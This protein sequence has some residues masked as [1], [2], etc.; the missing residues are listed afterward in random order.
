MQLPL[1]PLLAG[2]RPGPPA[3]VGQANETNN[4]RHLSKLFV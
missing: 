3:G 1:P 2:P 4:D